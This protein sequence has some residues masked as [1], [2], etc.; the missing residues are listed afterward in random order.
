MCLSVSDEAVW[1]DLQVGRFV[2]DHNRAPSRDDVLS[3]LISQHMGRDGCLIMLKM[4]TV[5][6]R[7]NSFPFLQ[8]A[9]ELVVA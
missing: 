9:G 4:V 7:G 2:C 8:V 6:G 1:C 5:P 3:A